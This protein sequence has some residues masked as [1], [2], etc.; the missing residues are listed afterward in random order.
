MKRSWSKLVGIGVA[1]ALLVFSVAAAGR[2]VED[3]FA[4][5]VLILDKRPP[6]YFKTKGA[7]IRFL[8]G[9]ST[10]KVHE[11]ADKEWVFET[12]AF[13][14]RPLGDYEAQV[15]F[16]DVTDGRSDAQRRFVDG[17]AQQTMDRNTRILSHKARLTRPHF[18]AGRD[19]V[20]QVQSRG[21]VLARGSFSTRGTSQAAIDQQLR[22]EA[23]MKK[24]EESMKELEKKAKEQKEREKREAE[25][26]DEAAEDLF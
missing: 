14:R 20:V 15:A 7:F 19:Y 23:E 22:Y 16:Y 12:M 4:G 25:K 18:D 11:N 5:K 6:T 9:H 3:V 2:S 24:M 10:K 1:S 17:Y 13:F 8:R 21:N 26:D